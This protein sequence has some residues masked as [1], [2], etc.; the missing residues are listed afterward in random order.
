MQG[1]GK[2]AL[3]LTTKLLYPSVA[4]CSATLVPSFV[5]MTFW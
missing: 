3:T 1:E 2:N 4:K 5:T